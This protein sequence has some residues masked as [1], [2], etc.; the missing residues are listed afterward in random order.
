MNVTLDRFCM[1]TDFKKILHHFF[2]QNQQAA[3]WKIE[4]LQKWETV[5]GNLKTRVVLEKIQDDTLVLG[6]HDSCWLQELYLL[7][8][9]I[10]ATINA[11][12][13]QPRIKNLRFK[14]AAPS[15]HKKSRD[16]KGAEN[17]NIF[18]TRA[19]NVQEQ[20][21]LDAITDE[22]L[23]KALHDFLMKCS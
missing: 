16:N 8:P 9:L 19:L 11:N 5:L 12:L 6:V 10:M 13:D 3:A 14:L 23:R 1:A 4:L 21:A 22:G 15:T 2:S 20:R 7:S 17:T 18:K